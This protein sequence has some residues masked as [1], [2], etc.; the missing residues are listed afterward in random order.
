MNMN[1]IGCVVN[2]ASMVFWKVKVSTK[3]TFKLNTEVGGGVASYCA[4]TTI[5]L[6]FSSHS[7]LRSKNTQ[8]KHLITSICF[9][10]I[11]KW[12]TIF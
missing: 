9:C 12:K 8:I 5:P 11:I 2:K 4:L 6:V 3:F 1:T 7:D 10:K